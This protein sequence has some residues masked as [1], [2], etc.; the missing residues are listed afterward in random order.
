MYL[1]QGKHQ[2]LQGGNDEEGVSI[3]EV[4]LGPEFING[5]RKHRNVWRREVFQSLT[6]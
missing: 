3:D 6:N 4:K 1:Q 5:V 2:I